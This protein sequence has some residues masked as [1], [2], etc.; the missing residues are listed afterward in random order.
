MRSVQ[1]LCIG[2]RA[3]DPGRLGTRRVGQAGLT[4]PGR[5]GSVKHAAVAPPAFF[6]GPLPVRSLGVQQLL[7]ARS[8]PLSPSGRLP[9]AC[10]HELPL[11]PRPRP[12]PWALPASHRTICCAW[13]VANLVRRARPLALASVSVRFSV[14]ADRSC[15]SRMALRRRLRRAITCRRPPPPAQR[16][17]SSPPWHREGLAHG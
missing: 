17:T 6:A 11:P 13:V 2:Y 15:R 1:R 3:V 14:V 10:E 8:P 12:A 5:D 4:R 9:A 7:Q 16:S